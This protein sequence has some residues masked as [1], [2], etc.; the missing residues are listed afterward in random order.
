MAVGGHKKEIAFEKKHA[1]IFTGVVL[2]DKMDK[3][4]VVEVARTVKHPLY[5]KVVKKFKKYS[6]HDADNVCKVGDIVE[7]AECRPLSKTKHMVVSRV[8]SKAADQGGV[9]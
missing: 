3:T 4:I 7:I 5:G 8:V 9:L 6:A 1:H 2:S